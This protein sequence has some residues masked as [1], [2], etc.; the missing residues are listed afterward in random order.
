MLLVET[1]L[2][3]SIVSL[4]LTFTD[5]NNCDVPEFQLACLDDDT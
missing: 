1:F 5:D 3:S 4:S 2:C